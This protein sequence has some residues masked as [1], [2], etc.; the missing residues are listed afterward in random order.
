VVGAVSEV[1]GGAFPSYAQ[2]YYSRNNAF[3]KEWDRLSRERETFVAWMNRHVMGT[4]DFTELRRSL[5]QVA[6]HA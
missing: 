6:G 5:E 1:K 4:Q 3:Y 2:G